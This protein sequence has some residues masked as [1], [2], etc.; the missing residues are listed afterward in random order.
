MK[1]RL[2]ELRKRAGYKSAKSFA[3]KCGMKLGTYTDYEQGR[4]SL[5]LERAWYFADI[6]GCT[7][8]ELAGRTWPKD[9]RAY[10]DPKQR[11]LNENWERL[12]DSARDHVLEDSEAQLA[13]GRTMQ[14]AQVSEESA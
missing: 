6:L 9:A 13:L 12:S 10:G 11:K 14:G 2:Q 8:D 3:E 1:T 4:T 7:L 5:T